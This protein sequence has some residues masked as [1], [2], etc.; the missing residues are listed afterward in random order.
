ML[1]ERGWGAEGSPGPL[2]ES[3]GSENT[4]SSVWSAWWAALQY[5]QTYSLASLMLIDVQLSLSLLFLSEV[6][7]IILPYVFVRCE[8]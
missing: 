8:A 5:L 6:L 4:V 7:T 2:V 1:L 3:T